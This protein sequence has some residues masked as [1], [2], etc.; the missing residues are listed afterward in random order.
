MV[1]ESSFSIT[2]LAAVVLVAA[3]VAGVA[4]AHHSFAVFDST[5]EV[6]V[7]GTVREFQW[8]NPHSWIQLTVID[9]DGLSV[10]Y[11]IEGQSPNQL[12][13]KGWKRDSFKPGDEVVITMYPAKDGSRSGA[14][15]KAVFAD[16]RVLK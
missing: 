1:S 8:T 16:G 10:E 4:F 11:S 9:G 15:A 6:V 5:R 3:S 12:T 13:R 7:E 14:F 2:K